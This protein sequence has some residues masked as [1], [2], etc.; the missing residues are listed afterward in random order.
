MRIFIAV[1]LLLSQFTFA[2]SAAPKPDPDWSLSL[3]A[4]G[5][6]LPE[7]SVSSKY[8]FAPLPYFNLTWRKR[9]FLSAEKGLGGYIW[10][11]KT[12]SG[13]LSVNLEYSGSTDSTDYHSNFGLTRMKA[14]PIATAFVSQQVF[15]I[16][17]LKATA[18][19]DISGKH[20]GGKLNLA[21]GLG[22]P[23][24]MKHNLFGAIGPSMSFVTSDY[25]RSRYGVDKAEAASSG[26]PIY[27]PSGGFESVGANLGLFWVQDN[28]GASIFTS[29]NWL[30]KKASDSPLVKNNQTYISGL[31]FF[32]KWK[33]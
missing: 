24:W 9:L 4:I 5:V 7:S 28:Y 26:Q 30:Q 25:M 14:Y 29:C 32:Y 22:F 11:T 16:I 13:G 6:V 23:V 3:G 12:S 17:M 19:Q 1:L 18:S 31:A 33:F 15:K 21:M 10:N 20:Y 2:A 8:K 27:Q